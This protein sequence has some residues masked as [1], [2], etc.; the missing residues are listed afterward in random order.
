MRSTLVWR[1]VLDDGR[2]ATTQVDGRKMAAAAAAGAEFV[3]ASEGLSVRERA[4]L[5]ALVVA[6]A[7]YWT[8]SSLLI[9]RSF[10]SN[11]WDLGL[12]HQVLWNSSH[13]RLF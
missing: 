5:G 1:R 8:A 7:C 6:T 3:V 4:A 13:G 9:H 12:I 10:H 2:M 11:G